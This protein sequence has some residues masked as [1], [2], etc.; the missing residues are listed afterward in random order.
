MFPFHSWFIFIYLFRLVS[1]F[2]IFLSF[3]LSFLK[4]PLNSIFLLLL[5]FLALCDCFYFHRPDF[6]SLVFFFCYFLRYLI[7]LFSLFHF[8]SFFLSF[9]LS[10]SMSVYVLFIMILSLFFS[11]DNF[12]GSDFLLSFDLAPHISATAFITCK[13]SCISRTS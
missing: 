1:F 6:Y 3:F 13:Q 12:L 2:I 9:F 7:F 10:F 8:C 11:T 5:Y 4:F